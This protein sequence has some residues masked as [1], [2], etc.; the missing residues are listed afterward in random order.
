MNDVCLCKSQ[1][2]CIKR[3]WPF[4]VNFD[5]FP[6]VPYSLLCIKITFH[7]NHL[8]FFYSKKEQKKTL[9]SLFWLQGMKYFPKLNCL[10]WV[11]G[12]WY[13]FYIVFSI[14]WHLIFILYFQPKS[15]YQV[16]CNGRFLCETHQALYKRQNGNQNALKTMTFM[17]WWWKKSTKVT[18]MVALWEKDFDNNANSPLFSVDMHL[19]F[20]FTS[21][22][23]WQARFMFKYLFWNIVWITDSFFRLWFDR[24]CSMT[25]TQSKKTIIVAFPT[26]ILEKS[27]NLIKIF[28]EYMLGLLWIRR[29]VSW[30]DNINSIITNINV[31][32]ILIAEW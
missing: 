9:V 13:W 10:R 7:I 23:L 31:C 20:R 19:L 16:L 30:G 24:F 32:S 17:R 3:R 14:W 22:F 28:H 11:V 25:T 29:P 8:G 26:K 15:K 12:I 21:Y 2:H 27:G 18:K 6:V 5:I 1:W 4:S